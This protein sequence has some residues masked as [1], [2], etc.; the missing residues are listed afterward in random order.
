MKGTK[1]FVSTICIVTFFACNPSDSHKKLLHDLEIYKKVFERNQNSFRAI[2]DSISRFAIRHLSK[3]E[4]ERLLNLLE[5][6]IIIYQDKKPIEW[7]F[8]TD[9]I[10]GNMYIY[11][12]NLFPKGLVANCNAL[13]YCYCFRNSK[14]LAN[15]NFKRNINY[16]A[17]DSSWTIE[18]DATSPCLD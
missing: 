12:I 3:K 18:N 5:A 2:Q 14:Q 17:I 4:E 6:S 7:K 16:Q 15:S 8:D 13:N 9:S 1:I 10:N 11:R